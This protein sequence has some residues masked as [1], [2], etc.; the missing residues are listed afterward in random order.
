MSSDIDLSIMEYEYFLCVKSV[1]FSVVHAL[2][3]NLNDV[4]MLGEGYE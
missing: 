1:S 4:I 2:P 3:K